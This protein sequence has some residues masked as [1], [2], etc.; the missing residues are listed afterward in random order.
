MANE[1]EKLKSDLELLPAEPLPPRPPGMPANPPPQPPRLALPALTRIS[2][3][4]LVLAFAI[5][6][7]SDLLSIWL[8][9]VPPAE[10]G[11]DFV[12]A[13]LLFAVLGWQW[14]LLPGLVLEAIPGVYVFPFWVLVVAAVAIWG[15]AR[16][17][18]N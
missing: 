17:K 14:V 13:L 12:T 5:A 10:W 9:F 4:R 6:G 16:P 7:V 8:T 1:P 18:V 3:R 2:K 15:S 11:V